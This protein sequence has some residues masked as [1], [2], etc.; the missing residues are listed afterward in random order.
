MSIFNN[1]KDRGR[2]AE[3]RCTADGILL[4][5]LGRTLME[6]VCT[7]SSIFYLLIGVL[8][9]HHSHSEKQSTL[10]SPRHAWEQTQEG[11]Q[12]QSAYTGTRAKAGSTA[13]SLLALRQDIDCTPCTNAN[14]EYLTIC[15]TVA[16]M[17]IHASYPLQGN[18]MSHPS[19]GNFDGLQLCCL[20][21]CIS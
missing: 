1:A 13:T 9:S 8:L 19:A 4:K 11:L 16:Y 2:L 3:A 17:Y 10:F 5:R 6:A 18:A 15:F 12:T 14:T 20:D 21:T 7:L